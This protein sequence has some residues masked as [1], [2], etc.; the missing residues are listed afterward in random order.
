VDGSELP[1]HA[2][3]RSAI[4]AGCTTG[5]RSWS[6]L[7]QPEGAAVEF[8]SINPKARGKTLVLR[9]TPTAAEDVTV[10]AGFVPAATPKA[11]IPALLD[12][13]GRVDAK[14]RPPR[15]ANAA[16]S[17]T[18]QVLAVVLSA[19]MNP[20]RT[21]VFTSPSFKAA[22]SQPATVKAKSK[23]AKKQKPRSKKPKKP[24]KR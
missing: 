14:R 24:K 11:Q 8:A 6:P 12:D 10:R 17:A 5:T 9:Y 22:T 18:P 1:A 15:T 21:A 2:A 3:F 19:T 13:A 16:L 23:P 20:E 7:T 4:A